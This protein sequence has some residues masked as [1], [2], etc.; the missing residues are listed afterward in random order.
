MIPKNKL[1]IGTAQFEGD[2]GEFNFKHLKREDVRKILIFLKKKNLTTLDTSSSYKNVIE[3]IGMVKNNWK[4]ITKVKFPK[5]ILNSFNKKKIEAHLINELLEA[6]KKIK[7][8]KIHT[9]L[10]NNF[11]LFNDKLKFLVFNTL[12]K[13]KKKKYYSKFGYSIYDFKKL[14]DVLL[15]FSPDILQ[16]PFN[17]FDR[18]ILS[19][20]TQELIKKKKVKIHARSIFLQGL[21]LQEYDKLPKKFK[22]WK[23][24][25]LEWN[26]FTQELNYKKLNYCVS[27]V[28]KTKLIDKFIIGINNLNQL[29][30][31][32]SLKIL[33]KINLSI[34]GTRDER[35][36][37]PAKW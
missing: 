7:V 3:K 25:F 19:K 31:I 2:Y 18:R 21:L 34:D 16:C 29:K 14:N 26:N 32:L 1:I 23:K 12:I 17:I 36:I 10:V 30:E 4:I 28:C 24:L 22:K 8:K 5:Q 35:L 20:K 37:N 13:L 6:K 11:E 9:L 27:Y 33:K 15:N